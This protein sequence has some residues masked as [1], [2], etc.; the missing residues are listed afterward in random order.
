MP[1]ALLFSIL[2]HLS[3]FCA[4]WIGIPALFS[5]PQVVSANIQVELFSSIGQRDKKPVHEKKNPESEAKPISKK[6]VTSNIETS[7][8]ESLPEFFP[9]QMRKAVRSEALPPIPKKKP[10]PKR[11]KK[12]EKKKLSALI[13]TPK[14]KPIRKFKPK[15]TPQKPNTAK[16]KS[17][18][19]DLAAEQ[20]KDDQKKFTNILKSLEMEKRE[21]KESD[22]NI[23]ALDIS[24][25]RKKSISSWDRQKKVSQ[26]VAKIRNQLSR[27]W[28]PP[29]G[30]KNVDQL[31]V[32]VLISLNPDGSLRLP[33][34]L[35]NEPLKLKHPAYQVLAESAL[36]ALNDPAC[37]PLKLPPGEYQDWKV[38]AFNFDAS[39]ALS[40]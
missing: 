15:K 2:L 24:S 31:G 23:E 22:K 30:A 39:A 25:S 5:P 18:L 37:M 34:K 13:P 20:K 12:L 40:R 36:R 19:K 21:S 14:R 7:A 11:V 17:L 38:I 26:L 35:L 3:I 4:A 10:Q 6:S 27:C 8:R 1:K 9:K 16:F 32:K 28:S 33:A 29:S